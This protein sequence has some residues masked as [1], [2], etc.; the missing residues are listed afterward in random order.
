M[1]LSLKVAVLAIAT[2]AA[3]GQGPDAPTSQPEL[4]ARRGHMMAYDGSLS[5]VVLFGG[6]GPSA[7]GAAATDQATVWAFDGTAW[8]RESDG[9]A[10]PSPR[11]SGALALDPVRRR[12]V[13]FGGRQGSDPTSPSLADTWEWNGIGKAWAQKTGSGPAARPHAAMAYDGAAQRMTLIGGFNSASGDEFADQWDWDGQSWT[14]RT[15]SGVPTAVFGQV[16][17]AGTGSNPPI[18]LASRVSDRQVV[19]YTLQGGQWTLVSADG[20]LSSGFAATAAPGGGILLFGGSDGTNVLSFTWKWDGGTWT[21]LSPPTSPPARIG[22]AMAYDAHL[23]RVVMFGGESNT[24][25]FSDTWEFDGTTWT[26]IPT[27]TRPGG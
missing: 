16:L 27:V 23:N 15:G 18:Q 5:A 4:L 12:V 17:V 1:S 3:C 10:G 13:L 7:A 14:Q 9:T 2:T 21:Q 25:E 19:V 24:Q 22:H 11:N 6:T 20:P 26:Q 8:E